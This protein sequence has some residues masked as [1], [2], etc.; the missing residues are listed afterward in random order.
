[1]GGLVT[2]KG[3]GM[4]VPDW[5]TSFGYNMFA[6][7]WGIWKQHGIFLEHTH[8]LLGTIVG[9]LALAL[10]FVAWIP[11]FRRSE[12]AP[13]ASVRWLSLAVLLAVCFQGLLGGVR[14]VWNNVDLAVIH[15]CFA[16]AFLCLAVT[17]AAI[18]SRWWYAPT[19]MTDVSSRPERL[20]GTW[21]AV[22]V[23]IIFLQLILGAVMRHDGAG[24][25]IPDFPLSY[26]KVLP[27]VNESQLL[28]ANFQRISEPALGRVTM[29]QVW[30]HFAHRVGAV[31]TTAA[32]VAFAWMVIRVAR[33]PDLTRPVIFLIVLLTIQLTLGILTVLMRKPADIATSHVAVGALLLSTTFWIMLRTIR[34]YRLPPVLLPTDP[35]LD[36]STAFPVHTASVMPLK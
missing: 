2:T 30:I 19:L 12:T 5:P 22:A 31:I 13:R 35:N 17:L 7:P 21:G 4:A 34:L 1:M 18:T 8:R 6:L 23:A 20:L 3:A 26:G 36:P 11:Y 16:Q 10:F 28:E 14:V 9:M 32:V 25:A 24:L 27:P 33:R 29:W 15:G